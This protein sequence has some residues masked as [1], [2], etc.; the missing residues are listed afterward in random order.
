MSNAGNTTRG[1]DTSL[2][3]ANPFRC[4]TPSSSVRLWACS[5]SPGTMMVRTSFH[6]FACSALFAE[7][8]FYFQEGQS[9]TGRETSYVWMVT[10]VL[11]SVL[12]S[13][14]ATGHHATFSKQ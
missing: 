14:C 5:S 2:S 1:T 11:R 12:T 3:D 7:I 10:G 6:G 9:V 8:L 13:I 4:T